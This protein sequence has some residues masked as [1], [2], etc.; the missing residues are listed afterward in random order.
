MRYDDE[1]LQER[2]A[3]EFV[4]GSLRG[5]A[6]RRFK[7]LMRHRPNLR[8]EVE[9]WEDRAYPLLMSGPKVKAPARVWRT[10]RTRIGA[11]RHAG[12]ASPQGWRMALAGFSV[13]A[14]ALTA[15]IYVVLTPATPPAFATVAVL[16]DRRAQPSI[17][18]SWT[19]QQAAQRRIS[20]KILTHPDMPM[21]TSWQA[22]LITGSDDAPI[23]LGFISGAETQV[24]EL[25]PA[26]AEAL[27]RAVSVGVSVEAGGG[28]E[29]GR[30]SLPF[31]FQGPTLRVDG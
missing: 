27:A 13:A 8:R 17:L 16:N 11:G 4:I 31:L 5:A 24:L 7:T 14:A 20:A 21:G 9:G 28:S 19:S 29:N 10:I 2:L 3:A 18:M 1:E 30:P 6:R 23:S 22:W 26:A 12:R 25:S 15:L